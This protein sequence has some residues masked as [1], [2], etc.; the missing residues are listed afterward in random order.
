MGRKINIFSL[1]ARLET[2]SNGNR[3]ISSLFSSLLGSIIVKRYS[4]E[5]WRS[6]FCSFAF[7]RGGEKFSS[8]VSCLSGEANERL[9][10]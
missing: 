7:L 2:E 4:L 6:T 10:L 1:Q 8:T 5:S 3:H 9:K